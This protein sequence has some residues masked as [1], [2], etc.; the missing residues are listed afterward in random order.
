MNMLLAQQ[1]MC[2]SQKYVVISLCDIGH[3]GIFLLHC[4]PIRAK[5]MPVPEGI[6]VGTVKEADNYVN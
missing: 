2:L 6:T 3:D 1:I 4:Q 5:I